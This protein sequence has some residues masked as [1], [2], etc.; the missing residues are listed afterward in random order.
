MDSPVSEKAGLMQTNKFLRER[1]NSRAKVYEADSDSDGNR[2]SGLTSLYSPMNG[3]ARSP[4]SPHRRQRGSSVFRPRTSSDEVP[5]LHRM[6]GK[7]KPE[8]RSGGGGGGVS[9]EELVNRIKELEMK[10]LKAN[11]F[12]AEMQRDMAKHKSD[13]LHLFKERVKGIEERILDNKQAVGRQVQTLEKHDRDTKSFF[14]GVNRDIIECKRYCNEAIKNLKEIVTSQRADN[15]SG[16]G[17]Q[18]TIS[19]F[20]ERLKNHFFSGVVTLTFVVLR[21]YSAVYSIISGFSGADE[22]KG[23]ENRS[24]TT[25]R[26]TKARNFD[27]ILRAGQKDSILTRRSKTTWSRPSPKL[28]ERS[29]GVSNWSNSS[30]MGKSAASEPFK[31]TSPELKPHS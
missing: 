14:E 28:V 2:D 11:E 19:N 13:L 8:N 25:Q 4:R 7:F 16:G 20:T 24:T 18:S 9:R 21:L 3:G 23:E 26:S 15:I 30:S 22:S 12:K 27:Q 17:S 31:N 5:Q 29:R 1:P 10:L 6:K